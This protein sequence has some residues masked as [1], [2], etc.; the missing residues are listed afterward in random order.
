MRQEQFII[1]KSH[2]ILTSF[3]TLAWVTAALL[4]PSAMADVQTVSTQA[5]SITVTTLAGGLNH[6]WGMAFLPDGRLLVTERAG[7]LR[8]LDTDHTLSEPLQG[9]PEVFHRGQGG[10]LDVALGPDFSTNRFVYLSFAEPGRGGASTAVGRGVLEADSIRD[11]DVIFRQ[12]PKVEGPNHFG[13]RIVFSPEGKLFLT[14]GERFKFDPAQDRSNHLGTV[15]RI[16]P[17]G[18]IP[19]DNPFIEQENAEN[20]IW[21][22]GH[23]NILSAAM[24]PETGTLWIAEM[25]PLGGDEL[26]QPA[27]GRNYGW[28]VVSWG[29]HYDGTDIPDPPTHPEFADAVLHWIPSISPS[30]MVFYTGEMFP[31][32]R[33]STLIGGLTSRGLV[34]V[35]IDGEQAKEVERM[36]LGARIRDVEQGPDGAVYVLTDQNNGK[37]WR[38]SLLP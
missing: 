8:I 12:Q 5:G 9:T 10:L 32:W 26:N 35:N 29:K 3:Y 20:A 22:Y 38:L 19:D 36:A 2:M 23:R 24:D 15:I 11:F 6:P 37:I 21:S 14:T 33:G 28:P 27:A 4:L 13:G 1:R 31:N 30:G 18:T 16:N 17:D 34:R 25:G 7:A